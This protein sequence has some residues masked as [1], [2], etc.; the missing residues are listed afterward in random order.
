MLIRQSE[1]RVWTSC[2]LQAH[3]N[4]IH[5][6][7]QPTHAKT[8]F[9][10]VVHHCLD[11]YHKGVDIEECVTLFKSYWHDPER[12]TVKPQ[13]WSKGMTYGGLRERGIEILRSYHARN[14]WEDRQILASEHRF[15]VPFGDHELTGTV[16]FLE[17][18]RDGRGRKTLRISDLKTSSKAPTLQELKLNLQFTV[19][20]YASLQPE[21]WIG[22]GPN[23]PGIADG[24]A[25]FEELRTVDRRGV[26]FHLMNGREI[27]AGERDDDDFM[28]LY[29][30]INEIERAQEAQVFVPHIGDACTFCPHTQHCNVTIPKRD[31]LALELI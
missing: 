28:R 11:Q 13:V 31:E 18:K 22:N 12:I 19:Y 7:E 26:W 25:W 23:F 1:L 5:P 27:D 10:V 4:Q 3:L 20:I 14:K 16:D 29:R 15:R 17:I 9:G 2:P 8:T 6:V 24:A 21:F 30:L